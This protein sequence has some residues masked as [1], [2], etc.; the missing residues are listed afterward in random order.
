MP[1]TSAGATRPD[2]HPTRAGCD[3][4]TAVEHLAADGLVAFPTETV[5]GLAARARSPIAMAALRGW[6]GRDVDQPISVLVADW[7]ALPATGFDLSPPARRLMEVFWPGALTLVIPA[8]TELA[9]GVARDDGA[10][11]LRCS[12]HPMAAALAQASELA[13]LGPLTA[14]SL[15]RSGE[16]EARDEAAARL[17]CNGMGGPLVIETGGDDAYGEPPTTVLD[18]GCDP[19]RIL[20]DGAIDAAA[21]LEQAGVV[22]SGHA[23]TRGEST[24]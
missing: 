16:P 20:R 6:K 21:L 4:A 23:L 10:V 9:P 13:G 14:T 1:V 22:V 11:G 24:E 17:L 2:T 3:V 19:P 12:A 18:L 15:N 5:W 8:R 7:R